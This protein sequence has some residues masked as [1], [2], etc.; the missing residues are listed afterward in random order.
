MGD[1]LLNKS[2]KVLL[3]I[4]LLASLLYFGKPL[5][6][7]ITFA[8]LLS[9]LLL[10]LSLKMEQRGIHRAIAAIASILLIIIFFG[11]IIYL[12]SWQLSNLG[13]DAP[14][15]EENLTRQVQDIKNFLSQNLGISRQKQGEIIQQ[16]QS[17]GKLSS[18]V[19]GLLASTSTILVNFILVLVYIFLFLFYR[20]RL[21]K[22]VLMLVPASKKEETGEVMESSAKVARKYITGLMLMIFSLWVM[23]SIG[24]AIVGVE[25]FILF[26]VICGLLE[27]VPFV[28]NLTGNL[29]TIVVVLAQG[30]GINMVIGVLVTY[31]LV[32]FIQSYILQPLV[33][34]NIVNINPVFTVIG[35]VAGEFIWGIPGM[36]LSL[37]VL[38]IIKIV[39]DHVEPLKPYGFLIGGEEKANSSFM[40]KIKGWFS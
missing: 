28:G 32:Q 2:I 36:V 29:L 12:V 40:E 8:A 1:R 27:I 34:G 25:S 33:V 38:A 21:K 7:P 26:A 9:M 23:Y 37:P 3:F 39:C 22:F 24:F 35:L 17:N 14:K 4:I 13:R 15:I 5:L 30:G 6:V 20:G 31:A 10:P 16:Q 11:G 19:S 18:I